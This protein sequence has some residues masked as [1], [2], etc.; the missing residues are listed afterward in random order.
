MVE[1]DSAITHFEAML[2]M[3]EEGRAITQIAR[4]EHSHPAG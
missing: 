1:L 3:V 2:R 4:L